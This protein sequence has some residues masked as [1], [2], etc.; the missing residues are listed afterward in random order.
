MNRICN[1]IWNLSSTDRCS[2]IAELLENSSFSSNSRKLLG[3]AIETREQAEPTIV[4]D[5][6]AIP[7]CRS[8]LVDDFVIVVGRS[9]KGIPW[10]DKLV[11]VLILLLSPARQTV[12]SEHTKLLAHIARRLKDGGAD[13]ILNAETPEEIAKLL[14]FNIDRTYE[15]A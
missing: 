4:Y 6:I 10:P 2:V 5:N 8:I 11:N 15:N 7:H 12:A 3:I 13:K 9:V 14:K 1:I